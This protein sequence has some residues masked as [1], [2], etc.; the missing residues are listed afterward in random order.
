MGFP[1]LSEGVKRNGIEGKEEKLTVSGIQVLLT[2]SWAA[3]LKDQNNP[4]S[5]KKSQEYKCCG[6]TVTEVKIILKRK[7]VWPEIYCWRQEVVFINFQ[8]WGFNPMFSEK[9]KK[10]PSS[11]EYREFILYII[12]FLNTAISWEIQP[13]STSGSI[14]FFFFLL[15]VI[16]LFS[17]NWCFFFL[18][19]KCFLLLINCFLCSWYNR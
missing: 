6:C 13:S 18:G 15:Q 9:K 4:S 3:E 5:E 12:Y 1:S 2:Q 10:N 19:L 14:I 8:H 11:W 17:L 16:A 7:I